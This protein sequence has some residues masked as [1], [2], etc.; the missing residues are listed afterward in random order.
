[1]TAPNQEIGRRQFLGATGAAGLLIVKP[2]L[3]RGTAANSAIRLGLLGCGNR[4]TY[5]ATS[6][7]NHTNV[8]VV[9]LADLFQ[10]QLER[11]KQHFDGV[12]AVRG[13]S[14]VDRK[15]MFRGPKAYQE[16]VSCP[17][18]DLLQISTPDI[19]H[20]QHLEAAVNSGK[21]IYCEKP[22]AV[23]VTG[24]KRVAQI[25]EQVRGRFSLDIGF[26]LRSVPPYMELMRRIHAGGLGKIA[27]GAAAFH[28]TGVFYPPHPNASPLE[29]RIRNFFWDRVIGGD[30]I[31]DQNIHLLD[32]CNWMLEA[33]PLKAIGT[34]GRRL[35]EDSGDCWDH[36]D[37]TYT[38]PRDVHVNLNS[39]Q[40]GRALFDAGIRMFGSKG[41]AEL[42]YEGIVGLYGD[43]PWEWEGS[44]G[45]ASPHRGHAN[46]YQQS[47][48]TAREQLAGVF[49]SA[50]ENADE[51]KEKAFIDSITSGK[52]HNQAA[53]GAESAL[54]AILGRTA[55][56]TGRETTWD[57]LLASNQTYDL[58]LE[59][60]DL[61]EFE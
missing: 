6:F 26:Q 55:A 35:R 10:D 50:L 11:G 56:Y 19:F 20:P 52:F 46:I 24:C 9:A 23:D 2:Q 45:P 12:A 42:H 39:F 29:V 8:R 17:E 59:G 25:G 30:I 16:L 51:E 40:G 53:T 47:P 44:V 33:H 13:Y 34:G 48:E 3:L 36:F 15:L 58:E 18:I 49:H 21:H 27:C 43:E 61:R 38:Y 28:S 54:T 57:D 22:V 32:L 14:G 31:V 7:A 41:V 5:V 37:V 4:G 1:M 60:I